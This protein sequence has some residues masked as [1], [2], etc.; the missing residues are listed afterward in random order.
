MPT[1]Q[2]PATQTKSQEINAGRCYSIDTRRDLNEMKTQKNPI[3]TLDFP[4]HP[5]RY[6]G[7]AE[8]DKHCKT[9]DVLTIH[10]FHG[11]ND[12][13]EN[14]EQMNSRLKR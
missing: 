4:S 2:P 1:P 9:P 11:V 3:N 13:A 14:Y 12:P 10:E 7:N 8:H 5:P 6:C